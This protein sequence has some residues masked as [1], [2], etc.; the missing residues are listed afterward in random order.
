MEDRPIVLDFSAVDRMTDDQ[1]FSFCVSNPNLRIERNAD[2]TI[3]IMSPAG[4]GSGY[5]SGLVSHHLFAWSLAYNLGIST[6]SSAGF[7]LPDNSMLSPDASWISNDRLA[8][9][10]LEQQE[11]FLPAC[12]NFV[13]EIASPSDSIAN[14]RRK[15]SNWIANGAQLG[16]LIVPKNETAEIY[17]Q[18]KAP[19]IVQGFDQKLSGMDYLP[20]FELDLAMLRR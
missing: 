2:G 18:G 4:F 7:I 19:V 16:W 13:V 3:V 17:E 11:K 14:L 10:S 6:D 1:L 9:I 12:P 20:G 5:L 15:M 8:G